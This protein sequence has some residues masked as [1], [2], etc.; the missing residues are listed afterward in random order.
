MY[1]LFCRPKE[2]LRRAAILEVAREVFTEEGYAATSMSSIAA[3]LG[4]SKATLYKYFP[5]KEDLFSAC[6]E[7]L[8]VSTADEMLPPAPNSDDL[9]K[10]LA[11]FCRKV[12][13]A[14]VSPPLLALFRLVVAESPRFPELGRTYYEKAIVA[15]HHRVAGFLQ[16]CID[17]GLI[18]RIDPMVGAAQLIALCGCSSHFRTLTDPAEP[19]SQ[20]ELTAEADAAAATFLAAFRV[21]HGA[22][23]A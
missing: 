15:G 2:A 1:S 10:T 5:S 3:R 6:L 4:G 22:S 16:S 9:E 18:R 23:T 20:A 21:D 14:M 8:I 7:D 13:T 19:P 11:G 17:K 12:T